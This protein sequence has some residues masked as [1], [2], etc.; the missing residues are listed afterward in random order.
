[1]NNHPEEVITKCYREACKLGKLN[2]NSLQPEK[3]LPSELESRKDGILTD[4]EILILA[5]FQP[6][7]RKQFS[8]AF[9]TT[10]R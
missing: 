3:K 8:K 4:E 9:M 7:V 6:Q 5:R 2:V 1:M 10:G